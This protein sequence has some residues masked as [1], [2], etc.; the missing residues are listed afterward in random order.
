ML[1]RLTSDS[2]ACIL[3]PR[4][5]VYSGLN[6]PGEEAR[7]I[8]SMLITSVHRA[9]THL[10]TILDQ[11]ADYSLPNPPPSLHSPLT[12]YRYWYTLY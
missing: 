1:S 12:L 4:K 9:Q 6:L 7:F 11:S 10:E 5:W 3:T 2:K 8:L